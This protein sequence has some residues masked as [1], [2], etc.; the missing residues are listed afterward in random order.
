MPRLAGS[1]LD[2]RL[3]EATHAG[4]DPTAKNR[5]GNDCGTQLWA[6]WK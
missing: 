3:G 4:M 1:L 2:E 6:A 5:Q